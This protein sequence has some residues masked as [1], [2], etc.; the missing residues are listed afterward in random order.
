MMGFRREKGKKEF[1]FFFVRLFTSFLSASSC[2]ISQ[3]K[4]MSSYKTNANNK[5]LGVIH[6][7][8]KVIN[9]HSAAFAT[10]QSCYCCETA[11]VILQHVG[12]VPGIQHST[13]M[14]EHTIS[15]HKK[16]DIRSMMLPHDHFFSPRSLKEVTSLLWQASQSQLV[17]PR[18]GKFIDIEQLATVL[19]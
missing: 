18:F 6:F 7:I 8:K 12:V 5:I 4:I 2:Q 15:I 19:C 9:S 14:V 3:P 16:L 10:N 1:S 13:S 17:L 11:L